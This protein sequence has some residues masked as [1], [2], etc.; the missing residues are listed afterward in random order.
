VLAVGFLGRPRPEWWAAAL[1]LTGLGMTIRLW[2]SGFI[3]KDK[4]L[5][6]SG[7]YAFVRHPLYVGNLLIGLGFGLAS[8]SVAALA[9]FGLI[10]LL[11]NPGGGRKAP[12]PLRGPV[13]ALAQLDTG[14]D[15]YGPTVRACHWPVVIPSEPDGERGA[16]LCDRDV[17][18]PLQSGRISVVDPAVHIRIGPSNWR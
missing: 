5:A 12:A 13:E 17:R 16:H 7:P 3:V 8:G 1:T 11:R 4:Q 2:A 10:V 6:T 15:P 14:L 9:V 18:P